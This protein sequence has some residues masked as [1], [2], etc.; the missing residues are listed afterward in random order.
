MTIALVVYLLLAIVFVVV[1]T[2]RWR[3]H[4]FFAL[5]VAGYG[6]GLAAGLPAPA[7]IA[8]MTGGLGRT[9]AAI[10][11]VIA[12]GCVIGG[13]LERTGAAL[14][15]ANA[16]LR[17]VGATRSVFAMAVTGAAVS[18]PVFCDSG[19]VILSP[20]AR[21]LARRTK[22]SMAAFAVAL[23]MGLYATHVF[24]PPTPGPVAAAGELQADIGR[25]IFFGLIAAV[26]VVLATY[27][28]ALRMGQHLYVEPPVP[29]ADQWENEVQARPGVGMAFAPIMLPVVL[30][31]LR[32]IAELPGR[33]FGEGWLRQTLT[34]VGDPN[35][36]LLLGV[37][38][39]YWVGRRLGREGL[40][41]VSG[42]A[43]RS[44]GTIILITGAGGALGAVLRETELVRAVGAALVG[45]DLGAFALAVP[46]LVAAALKTAQGS[47]TVAIITT[48]SLV[49]PLLES[50]GLGHDQGRVFA[51]LAIGAGSM[52]VSHANDS[53][54]WVITQMSGLSVGQGYRLVTVGSLVAGATGLATVLLL[55]AL[56]G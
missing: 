44:G 7:T 30:I 24:V 46:F 39:A 10:G 12:C 5:L 19:Y 47:S 26:P 17:L 54:F 43:L 50:I 49:A 21:S 11:I 2:T 4:P 29:E 18:V 33:P 53:Y 6:Y 42:E 8:A 52:T 48:A 32:S 51:A 22:Q 20:L 31:A 14:V 13:L 36:A 35:A 3:L 56:F 41:D 1:A 28:F 34:F 23:A 55:A 9:L 45:L 25:L 27:L 38:A 40:A 37:L 15:M 16:V